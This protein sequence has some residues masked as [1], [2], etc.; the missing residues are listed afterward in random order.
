MRGNSSSFREPWLVLILAAFA[1]S[2]VLAD[3]PMAI[4]LFP[5]GGQRGTDVPFRLG[6]YDLHD[7]CPLEMTGQGIVPSQRVEPAVQTVWFEGPLIPLPESQELP[8]GS[9][10]ERRHFEGCAVGFSQ[11]ASEKLSRRFQLAQF[12]RR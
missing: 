12:C 3:A 8:T 5:A 1:P 9:D 7:G 10:R 2:I 11:S 6:G 4:Y